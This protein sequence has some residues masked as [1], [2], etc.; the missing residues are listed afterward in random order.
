MTQLLLTPPIAFLVYLLLVGVLSGIGRVMAGAERPNPLKTSTYTGGEVP[1][2]S[3]GAP[4]YRPFFVIA[5]FFAVLHLGVLMLGSSGL[6]PLAGIYL[7]G[8]I[9]VLI[10]LILG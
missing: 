6:T 7:L 1:T 3:K 10:A 4:G 2:D 8:L 9:L 5:L